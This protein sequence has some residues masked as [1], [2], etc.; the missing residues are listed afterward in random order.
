[1][2]RLDV[3]KE[4]FVCVLIGRGSGFQ[5]ITFQ[6][7]TFH[8]Q[9]VETRQKLV[10]L[11]VTH[12]LMESTGCTGCR[13]TTRWKV[14]RDRRRQRAAHHEC[15]GRKTDESDAEWLANYFASVWSSRASYQPGVS[16]ISSTRRFVSRRS[17]VIAASSSAES[18]VDGLGAEVS[19]EA[20]SWAVVS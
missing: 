16:R 1:M 2:C 12:V 5:K 18:I 9:L 10:E 11:G 13:S 3:H 14:R 17:V 4:I 6:Y 7:G 20:G 8:H 19:R 15:A